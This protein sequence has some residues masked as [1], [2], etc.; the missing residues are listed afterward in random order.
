MS[1][2]RALILTAIGL[3]ALTI[4]AGLALDALD[5]SGMAWGV[6]C[7]LSAAVGGWTLSGVAGRYSDRAERKKREEIILSR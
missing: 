1:E 2:S 4:V 7:V 6:L 3:M 5:A